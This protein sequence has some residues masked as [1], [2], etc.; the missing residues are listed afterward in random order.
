METTPTI[1]EERLDHMI[2]RLK[3]RGYRLTPQRKAVLK[4]LASSHDHPRIDTIYE[5]V[6]RDFPMTSLATIYKTV[7]MLKEIGEVNELY[8]GDDCSRY[9][10][11]DTRA[12]PHLVCIRCKKVLDVDLPTQT[13]LEDGIGKAYGYKVLSQ[14]MDFFGLCPDCQKAS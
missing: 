13:K 1:E 12:H 14:R 5:Q 7:T 4:V 10:A 3:G 8:F 9:D 11:L 6:K 2:D